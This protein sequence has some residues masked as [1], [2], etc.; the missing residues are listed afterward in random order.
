MDE[1]DG[2]RFQRVDWQ[3]VDDGSRRLRAEHGVLLAG[4]L[5]VAALV[6]Y[7]RFVAH[8]YLV[9]SWKPLPI[10]WVAMVGVVVLTAYG[11]V[12]VLRRPAAV[13]RLLHGARSRR[14]LSFGLGIL[15]VFGCSGRSS[16]C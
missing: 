15:L 6:C 2:P 1:P 10:D 12:P 5:G 4:L 14:G 3:S 11:V 13:G 16:R 9:G 8:V 7:H